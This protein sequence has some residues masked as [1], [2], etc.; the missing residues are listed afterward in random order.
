MST[1][2]DDDAEQISAARE[3]APYERTL[4]EEGHM[5]LLWCLN[6]AW[7]A[8]HFD[9]DPISEEEAYDKYGFHPAH[10]VWSNLYMTYDMGFDITLPDGK[11]IEVSVT[12]KGPTTTAPAE[13]E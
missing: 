4:S 3:Y 13:E 2:R 10:F 7:D 5:W 9:E 8:W 11:V 6:V 12:E 1:E